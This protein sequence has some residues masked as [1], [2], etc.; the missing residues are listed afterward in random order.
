MFIG[1]MT[2]GKIVYDYLKSNKH[3]DLVLTI[4]YP[5]GSTVP[6]HVDFPN[7]GNVIKSKSANEHLEAIKKA[8]PDLIFVAGWSELLHS[9]ILSLPKDGVIGFHPSKLP[10][11]RGRS[12]V[13]WQIEDGYTESALS[14]FYYTDIPDGGD[15]IAQERFSIEEN[16]YLTNVLD[17][18]DECGYNLMR[19]YFP[20][21]RMDKAPR[22]PQSINEGNFRRLRKS[23]DSQI[24]WNR[25]IDFIYNKIRAISKPYPGAEGLINDEKYKIYQADKLK[26]FPFGDS[27]ENGSLVAT[28]HDNSMIVKCKTGYL[29]ITEFEKI[30]N[31]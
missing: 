31:K 4:C 30:D 6:R 24:D 16:D 5:D 8:N 11:D 28:L 17:K 13:A 15:I 21:I 19:A 3:V 14:M 25:N 18:I 23:K 29:R 12:V 10:M 27:Q 9:E 22:K 26:D 20:L 7:D 1:G 2:D